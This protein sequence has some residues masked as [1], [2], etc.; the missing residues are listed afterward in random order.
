MGNNFNF[1]VYK[2]KDED[3]SVNAFIKDG[4]VWLA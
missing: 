3:V 2:S 1:L 4:T